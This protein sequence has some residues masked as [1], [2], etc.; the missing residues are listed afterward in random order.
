MTIDQFHRLFDLRNRLSAAV[1][2]G[3]VRTERDLRLINTL[4]HLELAGRSSLDEQ[5]DPLLDQ[6]MLAAEALLAGP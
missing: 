5:H 3:K 6:A 4:T 2:D 1:P